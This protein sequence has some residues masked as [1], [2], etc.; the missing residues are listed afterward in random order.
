MPRTTRRAALAALLATP[1]AAAAGPPPGMAGILQ[2]MGRIVAP[3][4]TAQ[5]YAPLHP[6]GPWEGI[7]VTRD[8]R[9]GAEDRHRLD[10]FAPA[11]PGAPLPVLVFVHGGAFVGGDKWGGNGPFYANI[12]LWAARSGFVGVNITYRLAPQNPWPAAQE[13]VAAALAWVAAN[14]AAHGGDPA[15]IALMG[16]SAGAAHVASYAAAPRFHPA[17]VPAPTRYALLSGIYDLTADA[18]IG[19]PYYGSD[20]AQRAERCAQPGLLA[21]PRPVFLAHA[22]LD[23]S[24]FAAQAEGLRAALCAAGRCPAGLALAGH[25]HMSEVYA[26]GTAD[27]SLTAPLLDFLRR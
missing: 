24:V 12:G 11:A 13:D 21:L 20:P 4:E 17:G 1:A 2:R 19:A 9:Y 18:R 6:P 27:T 16:H 8:A 14:I 15:R 23:P 26:I 25:S 10:V 5:L 3:A 22:E 7:A